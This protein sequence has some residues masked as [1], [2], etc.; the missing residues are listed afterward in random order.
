MSSL[1][2]GFEEYST[3]DGEYLAALDSLDV[4]T[5]RDNG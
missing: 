1:C 4:S 5:E 2:E 3:F